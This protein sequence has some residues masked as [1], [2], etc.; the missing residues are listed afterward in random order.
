M[1]NP[2]R[3]QTIETWV[4]DFADSV[5]YRELSAPAKE[6]AG[7]ILPAF[8]SRAC[9]ERDVEP[10]AIETGDLKPALLEGVGALSLPESARNAVPALCASFLQEL[11][12][13]GRLADGRTLGRTVRAM[14]G[15]YEA[16][17]T[18]SPEPFRR[19]GSRLGR[20]DPC[21]CGSGKKYKQCCLKSGR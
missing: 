11:Q 21:P 8:L 1:S 20:N 12:A 7:T 3:S 16:R 10:D 4:S 18:D 15:A 14:R 19:A 6:Y 13:Q 17:T 2:F 5:A 9:E